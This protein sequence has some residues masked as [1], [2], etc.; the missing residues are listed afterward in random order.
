MIEERYA[1][2]LEWISRLGFAG[3]TIAFVTYVAGWLHPIVP[4]ETLPS[5]WT[6]PLERYVT[7]SG[8]ALGW[9]W[10][11]TPG[12]GEHLN[13][14]AIGFLCSATMTCYVVLAYSFLR[15]GQRLPMV[16]TVMQIV[17]LG[18]AAWGTM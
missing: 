9:Q 10:L 7:L 3:V 14:L 17:V 4:L 8:A 15:K 13:F 16:L 12:R 2:W 18:F 6:L 1:R 5:L 11:L